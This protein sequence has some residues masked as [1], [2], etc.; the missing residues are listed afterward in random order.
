M[1]GRVSD[2]TAYWLPANGY[3][4]SV[5]VW[6][7]TATMDTREVGIWV[8]IFNR[9]DVLVDKDF[10]AASSFWNS[11]LSV[12]DISNPWA[13]YLGY[14]DWYDFN[15]NNGNFD[16][17]LNVDA[18][19]GEA[20]Y[21]GHDVYAYGTWVAL[22]ELGHAM[23]LKHPFDNVGGTVN[24]SLT[25]RDTIMAYEPRSAS[26]ADWYKPLDIAAMIAKNG[27]END[28]N[29][30]GDS[31]VYRF[32][33]TRTNGHFFTASETEAEYV[34]TTLYDTFTF[35][36]A[37]MYA[38]PNTEA[39][40]VAVHRFYNNI[41]GGHFFTTSDAEKAQV[42]TQYANVFTYEG[43]GFY[44]HALDAGPEEEVYRFYN[45]N[46]QGHFFTTSEA[47]R[48]AVIANYGG[49]FA[50]EGVAFYV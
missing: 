44:V 33:N 41:A 40:L 15:Q 5:P 14:S 39:G 19:V 17:E 10:Y 22:H 13:G 50:Y 30:A 6:L 45:S 9:L 1:A 38:S 16:I 2:I 42:Q 47:E 3:I 8:S 27:I 23:G 29:A 4:E 49:T 36:G 26:P 25:T 37:G 31:P 7:A 32:F 18:I 34:A 35:E 20:Y 48:D 12:Q 43:P 24:T 46:S 21:F 28:L 11:R